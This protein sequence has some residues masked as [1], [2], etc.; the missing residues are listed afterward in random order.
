MAVQSGFYGRPIG[1]IRPSNRD[2]NCAQGPG[3]PSR[4]AIASPRIFVHD[5]GAMLRYAESQLTSTARSSSRP[6]SSKRSRRGRRAPAARAPAQPC[7]GSALATG[8]RVAVRPTA[9]RPR[10]RRPPRR[11]PAP[12]SSVVMS[13]FAGWLPA[14][15]IDQLVVAT[16]RRCQG[17]AVHGDAALGNPAGDQSRDPGR[18]RSDL[19][20]L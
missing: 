17:R 16:P 15:R 11:S 8:S 5:R 3:W 10:A 4:H 9:T 2:S 14:G 18:S 13:S 19:R 7:P 6:R 20:R 1:I 12:R